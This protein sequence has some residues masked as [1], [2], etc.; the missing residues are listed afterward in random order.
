[1][2]RKITHS[3]TT[4][5]YGDDRT[6]TATCIVDDK[7]VTIEQIKTCN[8]NTYHE[9]DLPVFMVSSIKEEALELYYEGES[10]ETN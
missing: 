4:D 1:M 6:W 8:G 2:S 7:S 10:D 5:F 3:F 9:D